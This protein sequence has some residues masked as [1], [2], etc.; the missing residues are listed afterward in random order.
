MLF[1]LFYNVG[2][3]ILSDGYENIIMRFWKVCVGFVNL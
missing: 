1:I 2:L 3:P